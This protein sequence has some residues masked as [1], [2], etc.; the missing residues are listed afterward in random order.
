M[1]KKLLFKKI[2]IRC[3][4]F[5]ILTFWSYALSMLYLFWLHDIL[6][7]IT[8]IFLTFIFFHFL[9][10][11]I[12]DMNLWYFIL[13]LACLCILEIP[14]F[15]V[16]G[17]ELNRRIIL[18][19]LVFNWAIWSL[20]YSL[21][22]VDFNSIWY[23]TRWWYIF[24]LCISIMYSVAFVWMFQ[25]FPFTCQWLND[26]SSKLFEFVEKPF[27]MMKNRN[28]NNFE[29]PNIIKGNV[30]DLINN[31]DEDEN[32]VNGNESSAN[33][34]EDSVYED[35]A[36]SENWL[37]EYLNKFKANTIDQV[38]SD[39]TEYSEW[40]CDL[41]LN[42]IN[43]IL[44]ND[45]VKWSVILLSYLLL[46]WFIRIA[47]FV[48]SWVAFVLFKILYWSKVYKI[49]ETTKKVYEIY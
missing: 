25:S 16:C 8:F 41:L 26:A 22:M 20:F 34:L 27:V 2:S 7:S 21:E 31:V 30:P 45:W 23:F 24:T 10:I 5:I 39:K 35:E 6:W 47:I 33:E 40:M 9:F 28:S 49:S 37:I 15:W 13:L 32:L 19:L 1:I 14:L 44:A 48:M 18:S 29:S 17:R 36:E 4:I 42:E 38:I 3:L 11:D 43:T 46:Y 12:K